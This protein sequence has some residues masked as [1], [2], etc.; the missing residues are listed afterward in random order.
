MNKLENTK[1][2]IIGLGYVGLPL[3]LAFAQ[4][5]PV[6]GFDVAV[7][8]IQQLQSGNDVTLEVTK[9][10]IT[11]AKEVIFSND[12]SVLADCNVYIVTVPTPIDEYKKPDLAL[13][14]NASA[15]VGQYISTGDIV[16]YESTVYPGATEE[17]CLPEV[18]AASGLQ[19]N[20]DFYAGYSPERISPGDT[21]RKLKDIVKVTSGSTDETADIV[22]ALY[23]KIIEAG[24]HKAPTIKVAETSKVIENTQR[25]V[26]IALINEIA[27]ICDRLNINTLD[28]ISAASTKWNFLPFKPGLVGGHCIGVDPYY[29]ANKA[30][31]AGYYPEVVLAGRRVN[32]GMGIFIANRLIREMVLEGVAVKGAPVLVL[33][34]TFKE[35]CPDLR[36]SKVNDMIQEL[37]SFGIEVDCYDPWVTSEETQKNFGFALKEPEVGKY[38]AVIIAVA[39]QKFVVDGF[40]ALLSYGA[41]DA[42][43][44]DVKGQ[45]KLEAKN[46]NRNVLML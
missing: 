4:Y 28:V 24:T 39:H 23:N 46:S 10:E 32:D 7:D 19:L 13:L 43:F 35:N 14:K 12:Q 42:I 20:K 18:E 40:N 29:L 2:G 34:V 37:M 22:D 11:A 27:L 45:F 36:N 41:P 44:Y 38:A 26:N 21:N 9:E 8:R 16:I 30:Q 5:F 17:D 33:G 3:A 6:V 31:S 1:I 25:D 15:M